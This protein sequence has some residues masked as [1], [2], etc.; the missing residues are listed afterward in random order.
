MT[1]KYLL[2]GLA[3]LLTSFMCERKMS[4]QGKVAT[5]FIYPD[6]N[7]TSCYLKQKY[8]PFHIVDYLYIDSKL[9]SKRI[10][11]RSQNSWVVNDFGYPVDAK[12]WHRIDTF[13]NDL[14]DNCYLVNDSCGLK[15]QYY[16]DGGIKVC[17]Y[18]FDRSSECRHSGSLVPAIIFDSLYHF[19]SCGQVRVICDSD[20]VT[21]A[22]T[23]QDFLK[24]V[25][26]ERQTGV[27]RRYNKEGVKLDSLV[28]DDGNE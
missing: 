22:F 18:G 23:N 7:D 20:Y 24:I 11:D 15:V 10:I 28:Y 4:K 14:P 27:W 16:A 26:R 19:K 2:L 21:D 6:C 17:S 9:R 5:V 13:T 25:H 3:L 1:V 12:R 8:E